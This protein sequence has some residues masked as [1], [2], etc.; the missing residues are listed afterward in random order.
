M[1]RAAH[2][3]L[4]LAL[5]LVVLLAGCTAFGDEPT[6][7]DRAVAALE[8][9]TESVEDAETY[10]YETEITVIGAPGELI[11]GDSTGVVDHDERSIHANTTFQGETLESYTIDDTV[12]QECPSPWGSW[13]VDDVMGDDW[14]SEA[15]AHSQ[16]ALFESG[17]LHWNGTE[18]ID[19]REVVRLTGSPS[20]DA[21]DT[22]DTAGPVFD[23]GGPSIENAATTLLIDAETDRPIE[24]TLE[25]EVADG[26]ETVSASSTT[27]YSAYDEDVSIEVPDEVHDDQYELGCPQGWRY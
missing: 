4:L 17:D 7:D 26:D 21:L 5:A 14:T 13:E 2:W 23:F 9:A 1:S 10:R 20:E 27:T 15:P 24:T 8:N 6:R 19:D 22:D 25:F 11:E 3:S 12:Y 16:L 18:T